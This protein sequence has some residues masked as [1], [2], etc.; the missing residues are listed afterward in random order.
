MTISSLDDIS[1][2]RYR[3]QEEGKE[4]EKKVWL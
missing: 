3:E 4:R 2:P 1:F